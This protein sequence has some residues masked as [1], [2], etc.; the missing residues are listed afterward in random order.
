MFGDLI[1]GLFLIFEGNI[2]VGDFVKYKDFRGEVS[3]IGAR[4]TVLKRYNRKLI[5][6]N[7]DL[8]Q[9]YRLSDEISSAW[10]E[11]EVG[12]DEDL[13][14]IRELIDESAEWYQSRIPTLMSGPIFLNVSAF[15]ASGIT[16]CLCGFCTEERSGSTRRKILINT[17]ELFREHGITLGK[18]TMKIELTQAKEPVE[19]EDGGAP[20]EQE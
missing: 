6:N 9:Y 10:V 12:P 20:E 18:K 16:I 1:A 7:S 11:I 15:D 4:V 8:K 17:I 19:I 2:R 3:E 5:V 14:K 13:E